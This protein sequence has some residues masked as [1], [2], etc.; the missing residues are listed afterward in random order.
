MR[1]RI[2]DNSKKVLI[3]FQDK[4]PKFKDKPLHYIINVLISEV[5]Q[6]KEVLRCPILKNTTKN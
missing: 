2:N 4:I 1:L 5:E 3:E 6:N